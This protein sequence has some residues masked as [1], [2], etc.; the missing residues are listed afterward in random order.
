M[1]I[2]QKRRKR[3][4]QEREDLMAKKNG[5]VRRGK[6]KS[7]RMNPLTTRDLDLEERIGLEEETGQEIEMWMGI[8][9]RL[10]I[11]DEHRKREMNST[12]N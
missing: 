1:R 5:R 6:G 8:D 10:L 4:G 7:I 2:N 12:S 9:Q 11:K 3:K